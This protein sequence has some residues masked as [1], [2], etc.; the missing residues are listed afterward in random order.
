M[1]HRLFIGIRPPAAVRQVLIDTMEAL[2]GARW[3]DDEQ[4]HLTLRFVGEVEREVANDLAAALA[5]IAMPSF[6][7]ALDGVSHF[8]RKGSPTA[9]WAKVPPTAELLRLRTKIDRVCDLTGLGCETRRF[10]PHITIAR[11]NRHTGSI[12]DWLTRHAD[13]RDSW[14]ADAFSLFESHLLT[15]GA[16]YEIAARYPLQA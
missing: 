13:L 10:T 5:S 1:P 12:A 6:E 8:E 9:I 16:Q 3:Q 4:L 7:L 2:D 14:Q 15:S 11:L